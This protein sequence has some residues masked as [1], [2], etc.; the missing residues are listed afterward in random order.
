MIS[1]LRLHFYEFCKRLPAKNETLPFTRVIVSPL[2]VCRASVGGKAQDFNLG[3]NTD[4]NFLR[5]DL[6]P[7]TL[8]PLPNGG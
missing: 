8:Y 5:N 2:V 7:G 3:V 6:S 1:G 4:L